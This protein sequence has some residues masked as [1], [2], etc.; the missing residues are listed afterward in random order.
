MMARES[1]VADVRVSDTADRVV[2]APRDVRTTHALARLLRDAVPDV[3]IR[4]SAEGLWM[5]AQSSQALLASI[6]GADLRWS[7][8][9][10][11]VVNNRA[12]LRSAFPIVYAHV[13]ALRQGGRA[14]A[15]G[16]LGDV[17]GL[18][19]LDDHQWVNV[20]AMTVKDGPG[21][22]VFDEQG[23]GKTVTLIFAFDVLVHRDEVDF[24]IIV[25][26]KSMISEW[27]GDFA[28]FKRDIY[29][30]SVVTGTRKEKRAAINSGADVLVTNFE[31]V[32]SMED[33]LR[34]ALSRRRGRG[35]LVV[36]ESFYA[37]N[38]HATR[39]RALR[40]LREHAGRAFVL[41][42][43]P[44]PNAPQDLVEQFN[45]VDLGT[46]FAGVEIP[47]DRAAAADVVQ[48][49][50]D[51]RGL[52]I[53]HTKTD[54]LPDLPAKRYHRVLV[55]LAPQQR[56][57]YEA[58]LHSLVVDL[59]STDDGAFQRQLTS[60]L[61]RRSA[62][63]QICSHPGS[64]VDGYHEVPAK[65]S[66]L[67]DLLDEL[68]VRR[69][70]K[71]I[72]WSFYTASLAAATARFARYNPVRYDGSVSDVAVRRD[73]VRRFQEDDTTMLFVANPAAAGAG[74]T[75]HRARYAVYESLSNQTAHYLQ[76]L[77]RIHRRGQSR[78]VE[79]VMLL[80]DRTIELAEYERLLDKERA[81]QN[82]LGDRVNPPVT[83]MSMLSDVTAAARLLD[84]T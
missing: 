34:S 54:V 84:D 26:P 7:E 1:I 11:A 74:L 2:V 61:A 10:K 68:I 51:A 43:T 40:R 9:A 77:D 80:C 35:I 71:V 6:S 4:S 19:V 13:L 18:E 32:V 38:L 14:M 50:I 16:Q 33:E 37:K 65:L 62:L 56:R 42:G 30:V 60:Y 25:A 27:P 59:E 63:L 36:D 23:A 8:E 20:A 83:R 67:D 79:Y 46:T 41:C 66:A 31:T 55:E 75:L 3:P 76:S 57:A 48:G 78:S 81:A 24:A 47:K 22:C 44:A 53:R 12:R 69:G 72:L 28:R 17:P 52:F 45:L 39:T 29:K 64:V 58:A 5:P 70:E 82:L 21:L 15:E 73:A 49:A